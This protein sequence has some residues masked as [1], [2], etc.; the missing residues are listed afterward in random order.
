MANLLDTVLVHL[1]FDGLAT[2]IEAG[3][4]SELVLDIIVLNKPSQQES[5]IEV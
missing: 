3:T 2:R 1:D 4:T 5:G